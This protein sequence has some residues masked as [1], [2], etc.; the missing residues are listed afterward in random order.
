MSFPKCFSPQHRLLI[1]FL[2]VTLLPASAL[3]WLGWRFLE[4][5]K[6]LELQ[7]IEERLERAVD[8]V[9]ISL[10]H[11]LSEIE[12]QLLAPS[13]LSRDFGGDA[14]TVRFSTAGVEANPSRL[15]LYHPFQV[16]DESSLRQPFEAYHCVF[17]PKVTTYFAGKRPPVSE[18]SD[19]AFR[20]KTTSFGR[21]PKGVVGLSKGVVVLAK[22]V[23]SQRVSDAG[24][25]ALCSLL[26]KWS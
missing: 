14:M 7:R 18:Q 20:C 26:L 25:D 22:G 1:L 6:A 4:Q 17:R 8:Q 5:D 24:Q 3:T 9:A 16:P 10:E 19:R 2:L 21:F 11:F 12:H 15:L 23:T 13:S